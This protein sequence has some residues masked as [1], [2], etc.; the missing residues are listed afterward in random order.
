MLAAAAVSACGEAE[1]TGEGAYAGVEKAAPATESETETAPA[2][3]ESRKALTPIP[4]AFHGRWGMLGDCSSPMVITAGGIESPGAQPLSSVK[5]LDA[6]TIEL[7]RE[8]NPEYPDADQRFGLVVS[9][10]DMLTMHAPQMSSL[11]FERCG[12]RAPAEKQAASAAGGLPAK[13]RGRW[14]SEEYGNCDA[15]GPDAITVEAM[16]ISDESDSG[17]R[18]AS[19]ERVDANTYRAQAN[20]YAGDYTGERFAMTVRLE[21]A[22]E[23][24]VLGL[25]GGSNVYEMRWG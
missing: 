4:A 11:R 21:D 15:P 1:A 22:G 8:P 9:G 24:L 6:N 18:L 13:F 5:I 10:K 23:T 7:D 16:K 20:Y 14:D 17:W 2:A 25:Q 12:T 3:V 19:L